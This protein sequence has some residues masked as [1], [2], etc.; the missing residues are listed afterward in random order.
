MSDK[1]CLK[2][3]CFVEYLH[4]RAENTDRN[5]RKDTT[6]SLMICKFHVA[7]ERNQEGQDGKNQQHGLAKI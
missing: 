5:I 6:M 2:T 4:L 1:E 7:F 3:T